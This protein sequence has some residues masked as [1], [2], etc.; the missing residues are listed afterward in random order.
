M[1]DGVSIMSL[2][3]NHILPRITDL[4][5]SV[6][7][8][9]RQREKI[10]PQAR[11]RVL[12]IGLGSG[13]NLQCYDVDAV[14]MVWGVDPSPGMSRLA[15][16]RIRDVPFEVCVLQHTADD[17]P[18]DDDSADSGVI[19]YTL[20][21]IP[22]PEPALREIARVLK[23]GATLLFCEHG[24]APD[25]SVRRWQERLT[26]YWKHCSGGCHLDRDIPA[27]LK[28]GGFQVQQLETMYLPGWRPG[29]FNYWGS[30]K[31]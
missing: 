29:T 30:A 15:V 14:D 16:S 22:D 19:T 5:C 8:H 28:Q 27:I 25:A 2:Y 31:P 26:P 18:L 23:P 9:R 12:E 13:L 1:E 17:I 7:T 10:V 11:G 21:S 4:V 6:G 3:D 24:A 20:C